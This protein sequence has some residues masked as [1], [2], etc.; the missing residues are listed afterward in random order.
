MGKPA[1]FLEYPRLNSRCRPVEQRIQD[2][3][4]VGLPAE[5]R[6]LRQE[7]SRCMDCGTPFCHCF[8]C[9]LINLIPEWNDAVYHDRWYEAWFR[10]ELTNNFPEITGRVCPAPCEASCTLA[11]NA[12]PVAV[13]EI[14]RGIIEKAFREGWVRPRKPA[15]ETGRRVAVIGSGPAGLAAAQILRR[16]GHR[17]SLFEKADRIGGI[18]RYGIP[19]FKLEKW[20]LDRRLEQM[21]AE[22]VEFETDVLIGEDLSLRYLRRKYDAV[23]LALGAGKPRDL[24]VSGR[25]YEGIHF[26]MEFL[27]QSNRAVA[28]DPAPDE[29]ISA[30]GKR[31]LVI[32]GGDTGAD[33]V[34]TAIRQKA[35][36][37]TQVEILP[38]PPEWS[39][40][41]NPQ[42]PFWP[43]RLRSSSSHEEG[44]E[45]LWSINTVQFSGGY[46][47]RVQKAHLNRVEWKPP[48]TDRSGAAAAIPAGAASV[49]AP[50]RLQ[51]VE[52][53][54]SEFELDVDL[55][56]LAL[57]FLHVE[58][59]PL[60]EQLGIELDERGS[61]K[62]DDRYQTS[63]RGIF[64][65]GDCHSGASLVVRA[66][67]HGRRAAAAMDAYLR[68]K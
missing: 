39:E 5:E 36:S 6:Q 57:G 7:G 12:E 42:W 43:H 3:R 67:D 53:P 51:P 29:V 33:C 45:R 56:L 26:A 40:P 60:I 55:V 19:D 2:Y 52:I 8:G 64:A 38:R 16:R 27:T 21:A 47:P 10:L 9:P 68:M 14:E 58:H 17:V 30:A 20:I 48:E 4:E 49:G 24:P 13:R 44:C 15:H 32:G 50:P 41:W 37:V 61:I 18:L 31:V 23:L 54:E 65:A 22:G 1:G 25:G 28:G 59:G 34:G 11:I 62:V 66:I 63:I 35:R 46:D